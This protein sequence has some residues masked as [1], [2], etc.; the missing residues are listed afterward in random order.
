MN[1]AKRRKLRKQA[2]QQATKPAQTERRRQI[3]NWAARC[4]GAL[5]LLAEL[6]HA[7]GKEALKPGATED[8]VA[9]FCE[10]QMIWLRVIK[11]ALGPAP[12]ETMRFESDFMFRTLEIALKMCADGNLEEGGPMMVE[13]SDQVK[14]L[15][16]K[17]LQELARTA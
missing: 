17:V 4:H 9:A 6:C 5:Q 1:R 12:T 7:V 11:G 13:A 10:E 8:G 2:K 15:E 14:I 16:G 3:E